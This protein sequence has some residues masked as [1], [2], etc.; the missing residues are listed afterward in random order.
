M[1]RNNPSIPATANLNATNS[2]NHLFVFVLPDSTDNRLDIATVAADGHYVHLIAVGEHA[3]RFE[4]GAVGANSLASPAQ[5]VRLKPGRYTFILGD[6]N[7]DASA[8]RLRP[9]DKIVCV[10]SDGAGAGGGVVPM[11]GRGVRSSTGFS[12]AVTAGGRVTVVCPAHPGS[13]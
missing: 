5:T 10:T 13:A 6:N 11:R 12:I 9:G 7:G 3:P 2:L 1:N 8:L 4:F